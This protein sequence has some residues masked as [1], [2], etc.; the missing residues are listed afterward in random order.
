VS[1]A[2]A[3]SRSSVGRQKGEESRWI[4]HPPAQC[5]AGSRERREGRLAEIV[6]LDEVGSKGRIGGREDWYARVV[7]VGCCYAA[8]DLA[9]HVTHVDRT[10][11]R[12]LPESFGGRLFTCLQ[13][14]TMVS[15]ISSASANN[16]RSCLKPASR[17]K[18]YSNI[19]FLSP[20]SSSVG[21]M[22]W[23]NDGSDMVGAT[24]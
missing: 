18:K 9:N 5:I 3:K 16:V 23:A 21:G 2:Q 14:E 4:T 13:G 12:R 17:L 22:I 7:D 15:S 1:L 24:S 10:T 20:S 19:S 6:G 8:R 11:I